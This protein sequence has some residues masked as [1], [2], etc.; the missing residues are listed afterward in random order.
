MAGLDGVEPALLDAARGLG[1]SPRQVLLRVALPLAL[2]A[3]LAGLRIATVQTVGLAVVAALIGAGGLGELVFQGLGEY[4]ADLVLLGALPAVAMALAADAGLRL[5][6]RP[7]R[8]P[9][10]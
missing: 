9:A 8:A 3:L 5:A 10:A 1:F 7:R 6:V 4:A 2:P